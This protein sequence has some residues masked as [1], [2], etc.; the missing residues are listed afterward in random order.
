MQLV[1]RPAGLEGCVLADVQGARGESGHLDRR[2]LNYKSIVCPLRRDYG[3]AGVGGKEESHLY[4]PPPRI[5]C[6][7]AAQTPRGPQKTFR[8]SGPKTRFRPP[9]AR[10]DATIT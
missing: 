6:R 7:P 8:G 9:W 3:A 5:T 1:S 4:P 10:E 2:S